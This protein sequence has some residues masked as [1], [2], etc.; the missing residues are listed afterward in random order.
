MKPHQHAELI[1]LWAD[2]AE[3]EYYRY[4]TQVW[5]LM[6][7]PN[8]GVDTEYRVKIESTTTE[9]FIRQY[10]SMSDNNTHETFTKSNPHKHNL[11]M[12]WEGDTL[13]KAE[14]L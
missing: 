6:E 1:K 14:V 2:G 7:Y 3:I 9:T 4:N 10:R 12:T 8:W 11:R 5:V 13:I